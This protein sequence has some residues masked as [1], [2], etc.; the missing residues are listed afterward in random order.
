MCQSSQPLGITILSMKVLA[1]TTRES[2]PHA[3]PKYTIP[4]PL[5]LHLTNTN[6]CNISPHPSQML[7]N[8]CEKTWWNLNRHICVC[9]CDKTCVSFTLKFWACCKPVLNSGEQKKLEFQL[10]GKSFN[11]LNGHLI[12]LLCCYGSRNSIIR[13]WVKL[14]ILQRSFD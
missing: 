10:G 14:H 6:P 11:R 5:I 13:V 1:N 4:A 12:S 3:R 9:L 2:L 8:N 7:P